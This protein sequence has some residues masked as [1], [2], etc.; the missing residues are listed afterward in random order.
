MAPVRILTI[1]KNPTCVE[2][3]TADLPDASIP[4]CGNFQ[5]PAPADLGVS[6]QIPEHRR[7]NQPADAGHHPQA[8]PGP[9]EPGPVAAPQAQRLRTHKQAE[10]QRQQSGR[11]I[12]V[13]GQAQ[14]GAGDKIMSELSGFPAP[15]I[16]IGRKNDK[17]RQHIGPIAG[18]IHDQKPE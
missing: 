15:P 7:S 1:D 10:D 8:E 14:P 17:E 6:E 4:F 5:G 9:F 12:A 16:K 18:P 13:L 3:M 11:K 2:Q